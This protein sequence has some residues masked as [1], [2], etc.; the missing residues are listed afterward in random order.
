MVHAPAVTV[1]A[2]TAPDVTVAVAW[3]TV[4]HVPPE[5]VTAGAVVYPAHAEVTVT[6]TDEVPRRAVAV[7]VH[8]EPPD[9][10]L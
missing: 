7:A 1:M 9:E 6:S 3:G 10:I 5:N 4:V 8:V 2:V